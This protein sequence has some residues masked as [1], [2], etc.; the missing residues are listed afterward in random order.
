[1]AVAWLKSGN[2][3]TPGDPQPPG[4]PVDADRNQLADVPAPRRA[5]SARPARSGLVPAAHGR[6]AGSGNRVRAA[7]RYRSP[8]RPGRRCPAAR[9][10]PRHNRGRPAGPPDLLIMRSWH[11]SELQVKLLGP[12]LP[13]PVGGTDQGDQA[14]PEDQRREHDGQRHG[15]G[16]P[17]RCAPGRRCGRWPGSNAIRTPRAAVTDPAR[18]A[19]WPAGRPAGP[20]PGSA[21]ATGRAG[22]PATRQ[23]TGD[24]STS[25][26]IDDEGQTGPEEA[27]IQLDAGDRLG[28]PGRPDRHQRRGRDGD[29]HGEQPAAGGDRRGPGQGQ[30]EAAWVLV[31]PR[32]ASMGN[33]AASRISWRTMSGLRTAS[34]SSAS[35]R[36]EQRPGLI[37]AGRMARSRTPPARGQVHEAERRRRT[38]SAGPARGRRR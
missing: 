32:R 12:V 36:S 17:A 2:V 3:A 1:M 38:G 23:A 5:E 26:A 7:G 20:R 37:A 8:G 13:V 9:S 22:R 11:A 4:T 33:S 24:G 30:A 15:A 21:T 29:G 6:P 10:R 25:G 18:P 31:I 19:R 14:G 35:E 28:Q 34:V 27:R 16:A